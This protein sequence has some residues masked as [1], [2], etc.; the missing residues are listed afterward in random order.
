MAGSA[1]ASQ[2]SRLVLCPHGIPPER[3]ALCTALLH[4]CGGDLNRMIDAP[5]G[6]AAFL[7]HLKRLKGML[8]ALRPPIVLLTSV[9]PLRLQVL[10]LREHYERELPVLQQADWILFVDDSPVAFVREALQQGRVERGPSFALLHALE[11]RYLIVTADEVEAPALAAGM[12]A[13]HRP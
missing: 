8:E 11:R 13:L 3:R 12:A 6:A 5:A 1:T 10:Q 2:Q 7:A 9:T 4:Y